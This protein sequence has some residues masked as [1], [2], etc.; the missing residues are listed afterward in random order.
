LKNDVV[1]FLDPTIRAE[2]VTQVS[3]TDGAP[4][5]DEVQENA[6]PRVAINFVICKYGVIAFISLFCWFLRA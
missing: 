3:T 2:V 1:G 4:V 6:I 5:N